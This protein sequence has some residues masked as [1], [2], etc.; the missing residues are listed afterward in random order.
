MISGMPN[1]VRTNTTL[2]NVNSPSQN[3]MLKISII[4]TI[5]TAD[6]PQAVYKRRRTVDP[7]NN[8]P[9]LFPTA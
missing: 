6:T 8:V 1:G 7:P 5:S 3:V 4:L 9:K 2:D